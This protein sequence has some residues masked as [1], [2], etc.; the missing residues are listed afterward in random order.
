MVRALP[1]ALALL[2]GLALRLWMLGHVFEVSGDSL[3]YGGLA[4]NLLLHGQYDLTTA[5]GKM[6]P[7][8]IRLPGYPLFLAVCFR[9]FGMEN[10]YSAA[11]AQIGLDLISCL[12]LADFARRIAPA[13]LGRRAAL[14][15]LWLAALCPFTASYTAEP[16]TE[17]PTLFVLALCL[18][19]MARFRDE[20]S[21]TNAL[22]FTAAVSY[23][24]LL[25][26]DGAL[27]GIVF[28][29][30]LFRGRN[31]DV[32]HAIFPGPQ[33][34]GIST[35]RTKTS[36]WGPRT[37][38]TL[39]RVNRASDRVVNGVPAMRFSRMAA[40]CVLLALAP[41]AVWTVRNWRVFHVF[42]P[43]APRLATDPGESG[44]PGWERWVKSWCL[45]YIST[46]EIYWNVPGD[47]LDVTEL[48]N[49]AFDTPAQY[50][51]TAALAADYNDHGMALTPEIDARFGELAA[52]R[53][54]AHPL[55]SYV[56]LPLGRLGDMWLRPR[57]EDL[58]IDLD[59]WVYGHHRAETRFCWGYAGLNAVY[60]ILGIGGL[61]LRPRFWGAMLAYMVLRSAL[62][63]TIEAP[64]TRYT[65]EC[66]PMLFAGGGI[67]IAW[68]IG[69]FRA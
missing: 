28:A 52:E 55:R 29:F 8:L 41:F 27:A 60:L 23:A 7:T 4:K 13:G 5:A 61:F 37:G 62:L 1:I 49:R 21:W 65:L 36:P 17:T 64:E 18:W 26:P 51:E 54:A 59:W 25:R 63:L 43:L 46:Y 57:V 53:I 6:Y 69:R 39:E 40:V 22:W 58:D 12:L 19:A 24:T 2:A 11:C 42:E 16:L 9:L 15:A 30:F 32:R 47:E 3:V 44:N 45:D 50:A 68:L 56:W 67:A 48:P 31:Q 33:G 35:P 34:R 10:Y 66:F 20:P 38:G 14:A